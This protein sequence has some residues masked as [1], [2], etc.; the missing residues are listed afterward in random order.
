MIHCDSVEEELARSQGLE[1][2]TMVFEA[3]ET[4]Y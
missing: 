4:K 1:I 3:I 2:V